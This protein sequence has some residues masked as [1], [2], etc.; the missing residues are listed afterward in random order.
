LDPN[1][2]PAYAAAGFF[3][4]Y[5]GRAEDGFAGVETACA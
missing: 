1:Y 2:A 3:K 5:L 4:I